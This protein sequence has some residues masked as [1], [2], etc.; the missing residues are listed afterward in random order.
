MRAWT[1]VSAALLALAAW[2]W[3]ARGGA[4]G[5]EPLASNPVEARQRQLLKE[6][7]G[8]AGDPDLVSAYRAINVKHFSGAL[9]DIAVR[10]EPGLDAVGASADRAFTLEGMFGRIGTRDL[11]LLNPRLQTDPPAL[12]RALCHEMV[13]AYLFA[14]GEKTTNHGPAFKEVLQRLSS[15]G[16][17]EGI[18]ASAD[19]RARL[20]AWLDEESAR[21]DAEKAAVDAM[22]P[23]VAPDNADAFNE[24]V[25][26]DQRDLAHFNDEVT[27]YK[28]M[29]V[30]PDGID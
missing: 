1:V 22:R 16:A 26:R 25:L 14:T 6:N 18:A 28:L 29:I 5:A 9:P 7:A 19:E 30:Y 4:P 23:T 10:W 21:L 3:W 2:A 11:I 8:R 24:R 27:R 13:H 15:E 20:K 12:T 17:F